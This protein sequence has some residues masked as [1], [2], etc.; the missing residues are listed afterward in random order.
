MIVVDLMSF[1]TFYIEISHYLVY[2]MIFNRDILNF[3]TSFLLLFMTSTSTFI[4]SP[5][6][7]PEYGIL[8]INFNGFDVQFNDQSIL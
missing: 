1:E 2:L 8:T 7:K 6:T 3:C 4:A 5:G